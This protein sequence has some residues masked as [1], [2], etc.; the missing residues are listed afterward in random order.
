MVVRHVVAVSNLDDEG[1]V[2]DP[3][4]ARHCVIRDGRL[5][6]VSGPVDPLTHLNRD[7]PDHLLGECVIAES[8]R[9]GATVLTDTDRPFRFAHP[10]PAAYTRHGRV[11]IDAR[12][13]EWLGIHRER[14]EEVRG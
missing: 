3:T 12:R 9:P 13:L 11:D 2:A 14:R 7:F 8:L 6:Q 4:Q 5:W 1:F 10:R